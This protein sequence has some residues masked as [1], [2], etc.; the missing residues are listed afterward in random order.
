LPVTAFHTTASSKRLII[1]ALALAFEQGSL[2]LPDEPWLF[3]ELLAYEQERLPGGTLRFGAPPGG[4]DDGVMALALALHAAQGRID[5]TQIQSA[6]TRQFNT[7][8]DGPAADL[9]RGW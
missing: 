2:H 1:E 4:H 5:I 7:W 3:D 9:T 8:G 6:G